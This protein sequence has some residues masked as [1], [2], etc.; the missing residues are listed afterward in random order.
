[1][2]QENNTKEFKTFLEGLEQVDFISLITEFKRLE[3][4]KNISYKCK[5]EF[6]KKVSSKELN[7]ILFSEEFIKIFY[8]EPQ[9]KYIKDK[10][11][12][13]DLDI[14]ET[15][16]YC[17]NCIAREFNKKI[18]EEKLKDKLL[19][20]GYKL[21]EFLTY[22]ENESDENFDERTEEYYSKLDGLKVKCVLDVSKIGLMGSFDS[23]EE[24]E[25]KFFYSKGRNCLMLMPKRSRTRGFSISKRFYYK[26][27]KK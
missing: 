18:E 8:L 14:L 6:L 17:Y 7:E 1:M 10:L 4:D 11:N 23:T 22:K 26:E 3:E 5:E 24:I 20:E 21:G 2:N 15:L 12:Y 19:N 16:V 9:A 27:L 13:D 25:G